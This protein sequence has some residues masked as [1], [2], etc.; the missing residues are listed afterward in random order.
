MP[1]PI[2]PLDSLHAALAPVPAPSSAPGDALAWG[3]VGA[4]G[5]ALLQQLLGSG[6]QRRLHVAVRQPMSST[7]RGFAPW[8]VPPQWQAAA[9]LP[10]IDTAWLC[11]TGPDSFVSKQEPLA[12][13]T[14]ADLLQAARSAC[15]AG[16]RTVAVVAPLAALLQMS[17]AA[18]HLG[19][20]AELALTQLGLERLLIVHPTDRAGDAGRLRGPARWVTAAARALADIMLPA[21]ATALSAGGAARAIVALMRTPHRGVQVLGA[22]EL[23][24]LLAEVDP[25]LAPVRRHRW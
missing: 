4:L 10:A 15:A 14:R 12:T 11:L 3:C 19:D 9:T 21:Y 25:A 17:S 5:D 7:S 16:A 6:L 8:V 24:A 18:H 2:A 1:S 22:R 23:L 20:D 13:L